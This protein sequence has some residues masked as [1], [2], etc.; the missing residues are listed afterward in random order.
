MK[1]VVL[2]QIIE[3]EDSEEEREVGRL[4]EEEEEQEKE[5][6]VEVEMDGFMAGLGRH[7]Q[8]AAS[9]SD[10]L[11]NLANMQEH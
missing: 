7:A 8:N 5:V 9:P 11:P 2:R 3:T 4:K 10:P 6:T 1:L